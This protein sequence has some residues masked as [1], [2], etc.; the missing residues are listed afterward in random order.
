MWTAAHFH[1]PTER[2]GGGGGGGRVSCSALFS[3]G[4][5]GGGGLAATF[6]TPM[7]SLPAV[8]N[9][10]APAASWACGGGASEGA[11]FHL[12]N[13]FFFFGL[14]GGSSLYGLLYLFAL[15]AAGFFC[16]ALWAWSQPCGTAPFLWSLA[17][18]GACLVQA[19]H[20]GY[21]LRSLAFLKEFQ[22]LYNTVFKKLGVSL[23]LFGKIVACSEGAIH[24]LE[25]EHCFAREGRTPIDKLSVLLSGR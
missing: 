7:A 5:S 6:K 25:A 10:T 8:L 12:A 16:S 2:R 20:V 15:L 14:A 11:L 21:R 18:L 22:E 1:T 3:G 24:R 23:A 9:Q 17:L 13:I 4:G 19:G